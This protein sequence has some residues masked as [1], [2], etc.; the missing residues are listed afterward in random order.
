MYSANCIHPEIRWVWI[1]PSF[2][3]VTNVMFTI[4]YVCVAPISFPYVNQI[5]TM[6]ALNAWNLN[7]HQTY[8]HICV[9]NQQSRF[10]GLFVH[11]LWDHK[12]IERHAAYTIVSWPNPKQW[13]IVHTS[14][15]IMITRQ[16]MYIFPCSKMAGKKQLWGSQ[17]I[18]V[19]CFLNYFGVYHLIKLNYIKHTCLCWDWGGCVCTSQKPNIMA[20]WLISSKYN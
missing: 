12:N 5:R 3:V 8:I 11:T 17:N 2:D 18:L 19:I 20:D 13:V 14:D 10:I 16:S 4:W 15:L 1:F 9:Q 7:L 6:R